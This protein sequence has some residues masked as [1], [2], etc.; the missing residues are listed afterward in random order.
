M[1]GAITIAVFA[2][3]VARV[4]RFVTED[5]LSEAPRNRAVI[6]LWTKAI[7][8]G[9]ASTRFP[10]MAAK[11]GPRVAAKQVAIERFEVGAEPPLAPYLLT[12]PWCASIY[13]AAVAAPLCWFW[14]GTPWLFI[15]ALWLAFSQV[16]GL[17]AKIGD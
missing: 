2:L 16:T 6:W 17:L 15:P 14:G 3:A 13:V 9:V 8:D 1:P 12:C 5:R 10:A 7:P 11:H 4:T